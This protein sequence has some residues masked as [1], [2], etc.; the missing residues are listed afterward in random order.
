MARKSPWVMRWTIRAGGAA[1]LVVSVLFVNALVAGEGSAREPTEVER[2]CEQLDGRDSVDR[3]TKT[4][5]DL[6][7]LGTRESRAALIRYAEG[8][9]ERLAARAAFAIAR[10]DWKGAGRDES[11][12]AVLRSVV[13][14]GTA[15]HGARAAAFAAAARLDA[16]DGKSA[17]E[18]DSLASRHAPEGSSLAA[19]FAAARTAA[20][21]KP[22]AADAP[23]Q[24]ANRG[25]AGGTKCSPA[26]ETEG[27]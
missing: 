11:A 1:A 2:L 7:A 9:D 25:G 19:S 20:F 12:R 8:K 24:D 23:G 16:A 26:S 27:K 3:K 13:A 10:A 18:F 6:A 14:S 22:A 21:G 15:T 5:S 17:D 4:L